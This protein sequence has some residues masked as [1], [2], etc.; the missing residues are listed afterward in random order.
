MSVNKAI[1]I[2]RLGKD[3]E[4]RYTPDGAMVTSFSLATDEQWKEVVGYEGLYEASNLGKIRSLV[5]GIPHGVKIRETPLILSPKVKS[6][7]YL[8]VGL[9]NN[10][11]KTMHYVHRL[12]LIA[13][14]GCKPDGME[15]GHVDGNRENCALNNLCWLS[16]SA[17]TRMA[18]LYGKVQRGESRYNAQLN[19]DS[20]RRIR[21]EYGRGNV[22]HRMLAEKYKITEG[23][24]R[25]MLAGK[26]WKHVE[27]ANA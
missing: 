6:N 8:E 3:P 26:T 13:F 14:T 11:V 7:G 9:N 4:V 25:N 2:G 12:V 27:V 21:S 5:I 19:E 23:A 15:A 18:A 24:V 22:T 1:L 20:V 10:K 16:H 17:N